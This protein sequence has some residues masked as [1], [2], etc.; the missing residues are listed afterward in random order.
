VLRRSIA[1]LLTLFGVGLAAAA[2]AG[3]AA[4]GWSY[5]LANELMS[6]YCPGR[7]LPDCPSPQ[8]AELRSWI[9]AQEQQGRSHD[10]VMAQLLAKFGEGLLQQPRATGFGVAAYLAP[11]VGVLAGGALL[12]VFFRRQA[13]KAA[14]P[15]NPPRLAPVDPELERLVEEEFERAKGR[16]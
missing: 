9:V 10:D 16:G 12:L 5:N 4:P 11:I 13:A 15:P 7:A 8:A 2:H 3:D 14:P 1:V 6:P